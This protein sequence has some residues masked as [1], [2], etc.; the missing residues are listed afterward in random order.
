[1]TDAS[2][3]TPPGAVDHDASW[4]NTMHPQRVFA[5]HVG[6]AQHFSSSSF[7]P[8]LSLFDHTLCTHPVV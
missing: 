5:I 6:Q 3:A 8:E 2:R 4:P 1:M 7:F